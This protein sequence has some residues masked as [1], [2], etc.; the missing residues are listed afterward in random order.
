[1]LQVLNGEPF[2]KVADKLVISNNNM[3]RNVLKRVNIIEKI[4]EDRFSGYREKRC[5]SDECQ[6]G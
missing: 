5:G 6:G 3:F 2:F 4:I 1:M